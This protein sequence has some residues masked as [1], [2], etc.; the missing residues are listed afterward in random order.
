MQIKSFFLKFILNKVISLKKKKKK[1]SD[2]ICP[3]F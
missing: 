3:K 2:K 1:I